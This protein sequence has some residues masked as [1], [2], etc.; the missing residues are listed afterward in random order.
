MSLLFVAFKAIGVIKKLNMLVVKKIG[1]SIHT[2]PLVVF[3]V[4]QLLNK[5]VLQ[6]VGDRKFV[7]VTKDH[8][9]HIQ[10]HRLLTHSYSGDT[11]VSFFIDSD[12]GIWKEDLLRLFY[13]EATV[14]VI[15]KIPLSLNRCEVFAAWPPTRTGIYSVR[16]ANILP[17]MAD[18]NEFL[19][20]SGKGSSSN[21]QQLAKGWKRLWSIN[22]PN[23]M[24]IVLWRL[25]HNCLPT[26]EQLRRRHILG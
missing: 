21:Q 14:Q 18:F 16:S 3:L 25:A 15:L 8:G 13:S 12:H 20:K 24:K 5:G 23:K 2:H 6:R 11:K 26:G 17:R 7:N 19:S 1:V 22:A 4:Q 9:S 10:F